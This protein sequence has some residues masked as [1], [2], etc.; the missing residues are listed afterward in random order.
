MT[1]QE[2]IEWKERIDEM[3]HIAMAIL[4]RFA[5]AGHPVFDST[6]PLFRY[7]D[8]RFK[9]LGGMTPKISKRIG[10]GK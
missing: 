9:K 6:L 2:I 10:L 7:F 4:W 1:E 3:S 8:E 5:P